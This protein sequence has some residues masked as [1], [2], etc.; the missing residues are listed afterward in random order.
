MSSIAGRDEYLISDEA[1]LRSHFGDTTDRVWD[2]A[3][4]VLTRP[5]V[6][7]IGKSPFCCISSNDGSGRSDISPRGDGPGFVEVADSG[8]L[9]IPDRPGNRRYDTIRNIFQVPQ[10]SLLFMIPGVPITVRV[11]G[12]ATVTRDPLLLERFAVRE[13]L[14]KMVVVVSV[15][16]CFG[17][18]AKAILRGRIWQDDFKLS[19]ADVPSL[20][21]LMS[22]HL[23]VK[24][25]SYNDL[26]DV[27]ARD[28]RDDMY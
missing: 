8:T 27:I 1:E 15:Q 16:E 20:A 26:Q 28:I 24:Q 2:K 18:C 12:S 7:F 6:E 9:L 4:S 17:H 19:S 10:V 22:Y 23:D 5:M 14:P 25:D 11:N 3:S 13:K 21:D